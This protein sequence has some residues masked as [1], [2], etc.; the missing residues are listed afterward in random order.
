MPGPAEAP[1]GARIDPGRGGCRCPRPRCVCSHSSRWIRVVHQPAGTPRYGDSRVQPEHDDHD[2]AA[3]AP[4]PRSTTTTAPRPRPSRR[5]RHRGSLPA[6]SRPSATRSCSTTRTHCKADVPG[7]QVDASVS[8]QWADGEAILQ[9]MKAHGQLGGLVIVGLSTNGPITA[10]DFD[11]MMAILSG[12]SRV[13]FVNVHVDRPWQ[14]PNNAV[15]ASGATRYP[16]WWS[17][18]GPRWRPRT[19]NGSVG[20]ASTSASTGPELTR[21]RG[22]SRRRSRT[23]DQGFRG[24]GGRGRPWC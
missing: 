10:A 7:I 8:R 13:V 4:L 11:R 5:R 16:T 2:A 21:W 14:D 22:W 19:R 1:R 12:A 20:T 23:G 24:G 15:L 17:P 3:L 9:T 6:T 18:T